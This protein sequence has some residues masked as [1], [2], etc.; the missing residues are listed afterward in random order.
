MSPPLKQPCR[1]QPA[2]AMYTAPRLSLLVQSAG[3]AS[4]EL[5][6]EDLRNGQLRRFASHAELLMALAE[7][8]RDADPSVYDPSSTNPKEEA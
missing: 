2:P 6:L 5:L 1:V 7:L 4:T 3:A 8:L